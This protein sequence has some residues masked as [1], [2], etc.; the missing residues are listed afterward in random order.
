[1]INCYNSRTLEVRG[2]YIATQFRRFVKVSLKNEVKKRG[3]G[4]EGW[5]KIRDCPTGKSSG[6][7]MKR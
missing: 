5:V 7:G 6:K 1:M 3:R 2:L 4:K